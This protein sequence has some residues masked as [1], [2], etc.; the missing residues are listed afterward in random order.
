[1][2]MPDL[3]HGRS[4]GLVERMAIGRHLL[5]VARRLGLDPSDFLRRCLCFKRPRFFKRRPSRCRG[6]WLHRQIDIG[7]ERERHTPPA[8]RAIG[9]APRR[10]AERPDCL[11]MI[12]REE[13]AHALIEIGLRLSIARGDRMM[14]I[15]IAFEKWR[16][17]LVW[18]TGIDRRHR[19]QRHFH[20][21]ARRRGRFRH[22][23][24]RCVIGP[25]RSV[26]R[27]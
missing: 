14:M 15:A 9:I 2:I 27:A 17:R 21:H 24:G 19:R 25:L 20:V 23:H 7:A 18:N 6:I 3:A 13:Q 8:H 4:E 10:F 1:M 16:A 26:G 11:G 12:E 5:R 22:L